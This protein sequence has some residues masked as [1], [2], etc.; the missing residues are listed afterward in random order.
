MFYVM[1][2]VRYALD[3]A[4]RVVVR[5]CARAR[6]SHSYSYGYSSFEFV[7]SGSCD[8]DCTLYVGVPWSVLGRSRLYLNSHDTII[9]YRKNCE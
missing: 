4:R 7:R 3:N 1:L 2:R 5:D 6:W 8:V 9:S